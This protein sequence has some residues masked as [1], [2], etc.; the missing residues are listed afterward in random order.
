MIQERVTCTDLFEILVV[1]KTAMN[2]Y[3]SG[4]GRWTSLQLK[5]KEVVRGIIVSTYIAFQ[6]SKALAL[7]STVNAWHKRW[8]EFCKY[9]ICSRIYVREDPLNSVKDWI[10]KN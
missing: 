6:P 2:K 4:L 5:G 7:Y 3:S 1:Q 10:S 8:F 9:F